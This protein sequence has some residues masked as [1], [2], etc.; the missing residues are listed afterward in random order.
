M[1]RPYTIQGL[2]EEAEKSVFPKEELRLQYSTLK[3]RGSDEKL[4]REDLKHVT[5]LEQEAY[6]WVER[7]SGHAD[8]ISRIIIAILLGPYKTA[9]VARYYTDHYQVK[10]P[11]ILPS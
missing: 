10:G 5:G 11:T 8:I 6:D 7:A 3:L 2:L 4:E 9:L 1:D